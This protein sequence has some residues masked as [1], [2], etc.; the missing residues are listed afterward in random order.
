MPWD[1]WISE[2]HIS[3]IPV[4]SSYGNEIKMKITNNEVSLKNE[5]KTVWVYRIYR[6]WWH[7]SQLINSSAAQR[8]KKVKYSIF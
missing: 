4:Q 3:M 1:I 8:Y 6:T 2:C 5:S 7:E